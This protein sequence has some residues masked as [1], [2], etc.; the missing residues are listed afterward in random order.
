MNI[1]GLTIAT[2]GAILMGYLVIGAIFW[3]WAKRT[4]ERLFSRFAVTFFIL[5]LERCLI[6]GFGEDEAHHA[7]IYLTRLIAFLIIIGSIWSQSRSGR[8]NQ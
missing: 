5:A 3:R 2:S 4:Q 6:L 8:G 1:Y 7:L